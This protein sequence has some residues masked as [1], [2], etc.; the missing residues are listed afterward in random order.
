MATLAALY[1]RVMFNC[2]T[3]N[4]TAGVRKEKTQEINPFH[5]TEITNL[6]VWGDFIVAF[7]HV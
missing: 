7:S 6:N 4:E 5:G 3:Y 2:T 1:L